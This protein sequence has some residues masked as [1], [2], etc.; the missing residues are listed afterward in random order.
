M[1]SGRNS[2]IAAAALVGL[3][4]CA[5]SQGRPTPAPLTPPVPP[6]KDTIRFLPYDVGHQFIGIPPVDLPAAELGEQMKKLLGNFGQSLQHVPD[7]IGP[8]ALDEIQ[9]SLAVDAKGG[10]VVSVG[11]TAGI[12]LTLKRSKGPSEPARTK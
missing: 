11:A 2:V 6:A 4:A 3:T 10:V 8:Y 1:I 7:A 9:M 5:T 12:T